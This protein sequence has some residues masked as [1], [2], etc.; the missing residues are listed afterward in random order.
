MPLQRVAQHLRAQPVKGKV[1]LPLQEGRPT[2]LPVEY[3]STV[4]RL[5]PWLRAT[6]SP[7]MAES[8]GL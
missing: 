3:C 5:R 7:S 2:S 1:P 8:W 4:Q 6:E